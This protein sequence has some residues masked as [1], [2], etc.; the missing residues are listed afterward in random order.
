[1]V[2]ADFYGPLPT[3][4]CLLVIME[5]YTHYPIVKVVRSASA[6]T[7]IPV[8]DKIFSMLGILRVLKTYNAPPSSSGQFS[9]FLT[10]MSCKHRNIAPL[11][12]QSTSTADHFM[13][14]LGTVW[15]SDSQSIPWKQMLNTFLHE[16]RSAPHS[17]TEGSP[18]DNKR[19]THRH[20]PSPMPSTQSDQIAKAKNVTLC[21]HAPWQPQHS[22][23]LQQCHNHHNSHHY[24][25]CHPR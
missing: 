20:R 3:G 15:V 10:H 1:M 7:D 14:T 16:Y 8:L 2:K 17:T 21:R 12:A 23:L 22:K 9:K 25:H 6:N 4:E 19:Y 11:W 5:E 18:A 24:L 13:L